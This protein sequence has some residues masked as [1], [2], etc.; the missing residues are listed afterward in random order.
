MAAKAAADQR[1][2]QC[3]SGVR[4]FQGCQLLKQPKREMVVCMC[5][6][7]AGFGG[8]EGVHL[9]LH[10]VG[11]ILWQKTSAYD[12]LQ[13]T[14]WTCVGFKGQFMVE[15]VIIKHLPD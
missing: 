7:V 9:F 2:T 11:Y 1:H 10:P 5:V 3:I 13:P 8:V 15:Y 6:C 12:C 14:S 4:C